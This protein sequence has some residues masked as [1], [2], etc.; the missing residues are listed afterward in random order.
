MEALAGSLRDTNTLRSGMTRCTRVDC[1]APSELTV[2]AS[3]GRETLV[4]CNAA[5]FHDREGEL[6][7]V[8]LAARDCT[9]LRRV[10][11]LLEQRTRELEQAMLRAREPT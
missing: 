2:R 5:T 3:D 10:Q 8:F 9:E 1:T 7:G 6:Q 4:S 11:Q